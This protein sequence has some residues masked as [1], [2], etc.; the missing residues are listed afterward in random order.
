M[1]YEIAHCEEFVQELNIA[2][3]YYTKIVIISE[4]QETSIP[5][6]LNVIYLGNY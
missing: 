3:S 5:S 6:I 1:M 2:E 4:W